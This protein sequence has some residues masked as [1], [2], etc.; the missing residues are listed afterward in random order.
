MALRRAPGAELGLVGGT[1]DVH[2]A[3]VEA[4]ISAAAHYRIRRTRARDRTQAGWAGEL[5]GRRYGSQRSRCRALTRSAL[6]QAAGDQNRQASLS[7]SSLIGHGTALRPELL[8]APAPGCA[9]VSTSSPALS[10][11]TFPPLPHRLST[12]KAAEA[13][14]R[15]RGR[16]KQRGHARRRSGGSGRVSRDLVAAVTREPR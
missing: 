12:C 2:G 5:A 8:G 11:A 16:R 7:C 4:D 3:P 9:D 15:G 1:V 13:A 6:L 10:S 14:R